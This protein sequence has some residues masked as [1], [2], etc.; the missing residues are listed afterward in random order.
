[1]PRKLRIEYLEAM[2]HVMNRGDHLP[3][4]QRSRQAGREDSFRDDEDRQRFRS[5]LGEACGK[6]EWQVPAYCL[7]RSHFLQWTRRQPNPFSVGTRPGRLDVLILPEGK[8]Q[9]R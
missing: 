4:P 1:M 9:G 5:T 7:M 6:T 8:R 2:Y 3:A